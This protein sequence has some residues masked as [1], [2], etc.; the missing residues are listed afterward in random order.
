M[1]CVERKSPL[2]NMQTAKDQTNLLIYTVC[3]LNEFHFNDVYDEHKINKRKK[4]KKKN[5]YKKKKKSK[6]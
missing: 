5:K 6:V 2:R 1:S 4:K 3:R